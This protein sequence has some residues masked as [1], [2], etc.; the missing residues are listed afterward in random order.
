[1]KIKLFLKNQRIPKNNKWVYFGENHMT[2]DFLKK[3]LG[4]DDYIDFSK[5]KDLIFQEELKEYLQW[6]EKNRIKLEDSIYW[7]ATELAG[8]NNLNSGLYRNICQLK[9]IFKIVK[10]S[11]FKNLN[12]ICEDICVKSAIAE[13]L[14]IKDNSIID[15]IYL[16][17]KILLT[18]FSLILNFSKLLFK[19]TII[20]TILFLTRSKYNFEKE[21]N[22]FH[23]SA[24]SL[25]QEGNIIL[26]YFPGLNL[27]ENKNNIFFNLSKKSFFEKIKHL[28]NYENNN[29]IVVERFVNFKDFLINLINFFKGSLVFFRLLK[30]QSYIIRKFILIELIQYLKSPDLNFQ[31]WSYVP[32]LN[33]LSKITNIKKIFDHYENMTSEH[34][35]IYAA[36]KTF[37]NVRIFGYHHTFASKQFLCWNNLASEWKSE[38]KPD[39]IISSGELSKQYLLSQNCP[40]EKIIVGPALRYQAIINHKKKQIDVIENLVVIPLSQIKDHSY[41]MIIKSNEIFKK[42][43]NFIFKICPHPNL[44]IENKFYKKYFGKHDNFLISEKNFR[45]TLLEAKFLISS[46][47]GAVYDAII[48]EKIVLNMKSD[49]SYCDNYSDFLVDQFNFLKTLNV[50]D[51][52]TFLNNCSKDNSFLMDYSK[53][54]KNVSNY[55]VNNLKCDNNFFKLSS[56]Y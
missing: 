30:Y 26:N 48:L 47:T 33:K 23:S 44:K 16:S 17:K 52:S 1:M 50:D 18:L 12:I 25:S 21:N 46:A 8:K 3:K 4:I 14:N 34:I 55:F 27:K 43:K 11:N 20:K 22:I 35:M 49:L 29:F 36:K 40:N 56:E 51:I 45:E 9:F 38:L 42:N 7:W 39:Y 28:S 6:T 37:K 32:C 31:I 13:N 2:L 15:K 19:F 54:Y 24:M 10:N 5:E 41:E 53:K